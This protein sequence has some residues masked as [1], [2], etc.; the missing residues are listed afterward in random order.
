M[1]NRGFSCHVGSWLSCPNFPL[2]RS[3]ALCPHSTRVKD[4]NIDPK[5]SGR[6]VQASS[7]PLP[8]IVPG[9]AKPSAKLMYTTWLS[10]S[11]CCWPGAS[12]HSTPQRLLCK[13][14]G[15]ERLPRSLDRK[16]AC[17]CVRTWLAPPEKRG[18]PKVRSLTDS[19]AH[20]GARSHT[21]SVHK[22]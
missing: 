1:S 12:R 10:L 15:S 22:R 7:S 2:D 20:R 16:C 21:H 19:Q 17:V 9:E 13:C 11:V 5:P 14:F 3:S 4:F 8:P 18:S 6:Q